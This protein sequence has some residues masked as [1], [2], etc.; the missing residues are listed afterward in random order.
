MAATFAQRAALG[1]YGERLA[2]QQLEGAGLRVLDRNW[3]CSA[4]EIDI[5]A[6]AGQLLVVC[7]VKTRRGDRFGSPLEAI[8]VDKAE[9]LYRLG[10][11]WAVA[12]G[13]SYQRLRV[14]VVAVRLSARG[15]RRVEHLTGVS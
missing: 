12:H 1:A 15:A 7:E 5:V 8:T 9:R 2:I 3:R 4:G 14:D 13:F 6:A 11:A 10:D